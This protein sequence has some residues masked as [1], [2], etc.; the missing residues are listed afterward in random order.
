VGRNHARMRWVITLSAARVDVERLL[1]ASVEDLS[2][3]PTEPTNV[4]LELLDP[5]GDESTHETR[6]A[7]KEDIDLRVRH[8]NGVGKL[9]WGRGFDG[10]EVKGI[11]SFDSSGAE[12]QQLFVGTAY[13][14]MQPRERADMMERNGLPRPPLPRG[15][16]VI[17]AL[18]AAAVT[19][20][21]ESNPVVGRVLHLVE[22]M[23]EGDEQ[24]DWG[25][26]YSALE[27]VEH[28]LHSRGVDG[29]DLGW[30]TRHERRSP[31]RPGSRPRA[32]WGHRAHPCDERRARH[33]VVLHE[34]SAGCRGGVP[35]PLDPQR[36]RRTT[37]PPAAA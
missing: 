28:D 32:R 5:F 20:L 30:W 7:V 13:V 23:L 24:I 21:A 6:L 37:E 18:D 34:G 19:E 33:D 9:R 12:T 11:R 15:L 4:L 36:L 2:A 1:A 17:E 8:L 27:A 16:E 31:S 3:H 35:T 26:A 14:H 22:L 25:A 29:S 10:V